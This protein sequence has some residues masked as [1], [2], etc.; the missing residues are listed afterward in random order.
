MFGPL[1]SRAAQA[2]VRLL[3][4][5]PHAQC[6][7]FELVDAG[8][9]VGQEVGHVDRDRS[10]VEPLGRQVRQPVGMAAAE[11]LHRP[12]DARAGDPLALGLRDGFIACGRE[13]HP[14]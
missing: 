1:G 3:A 2:V 6:G 13:R 5:P 11:A 12:E 7:V 14:P 4:E 8:V 9:H 10:A